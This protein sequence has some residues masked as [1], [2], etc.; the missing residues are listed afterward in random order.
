MNFAVFASGRGSNLRALHAAQRRGDLP[1]RLA[2]VLSNNSK[3]GALEYARAEGLA[4]LHLSGKT[5]ADP[6]AAML[7]ALRAHAIDLVVLAGYMKRIPDAL[8]EAYPGRILNVHPGPLPRFGG[9]GMFGQHVHAAV[10]ESGVDLAGPT[11][12]V[13]TGDYDEGPILGHTPV[14]VLAD[15]DIASLERRVQAAEHDLYWRVI[16]QHFGDAG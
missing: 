3:S 14:P 6:D 7:E 4:W 12:H 15:D 8:I 13:V 5:H 1:A 11:V 10:L 2:L 9:H 16:A